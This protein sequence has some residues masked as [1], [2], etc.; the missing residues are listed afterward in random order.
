MKPFILPLTGIL[1]LLTS[2][3]GICEEVAAGKTTTSA[4]GKKAKVTT[5]KQGGKLL[6]DF[7]IPR[8][9]TGPAGPLGPM[10]PMGPSAPEAS[11]QRSIFIPGAS[12][13][14]SGTGTTASAWGPSL[15]STASARPGFVIPKPVDW[16]DSKAFSVT[17]VFSIGSTGAT[18]SSVRWRLNAGTNNLNSTS[19][20]ANTGWDSLDYYA[21]VDAP[22]LLVPA[23]SY[24]N[25]TKTQTWAAQ[26]SNTYNTWY[27][28]T[29]VTTNNDFTDDPLW[30]FNFQRGSNAANGEGFTGSLT[31]NAVTINY[32]AK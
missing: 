11:K 6:F 16:D 9:K 2:T 18:D 8:G 7:V 21:S 29:G 3:S 28:G 17:V 14:Y 27:F 26:Y 5:R 31:I 13:T 32:T 25:L 24:G 23:S 19:S 10:G 1:V 20:D 15:I 4:P 22:P 30:H 12:L